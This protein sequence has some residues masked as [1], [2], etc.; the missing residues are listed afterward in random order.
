MEMHDF[1]LHGGPKEFVFTPRT[2]DAKDWF[3]QH[4]EADADSLSHGVIVLRN[5]LDDLLGDVDDDGL[6]VQDEAT[7]Q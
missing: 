3:S 5:Y 6:S 4:I 2:D 7:Y 1:I